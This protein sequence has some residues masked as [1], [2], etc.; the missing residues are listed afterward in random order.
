MF[1]IDW[2]G[3]RQLRAA[4]PEDVVSVFVLPPS[5]AAL[6]ARLRGRGGDDEAEVARRMQAARDE[7]SHW[8]E[9][10]HVVINDESRAMRRRRCAPCCT[11]PVPSGP[12]SRAWPRSS[13]GCSDGPPQQLALALMACF[14]A[15]TAAQADPART[16][17]AEIA[18]LTDAER[19]KMI[20]RSWHAGCPVPLDDL[21]AIRMDY[22]GY[23]QR[24]A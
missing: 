13:P 11:P 4:L 7:I 14:S 5:L 12:A 18:P 2:Q 1:D 6:E 3:H 21:V 15:L 8:A 16:F 19:A 9:F 24:R 10:D 17:R 20:G 23:D 22:F